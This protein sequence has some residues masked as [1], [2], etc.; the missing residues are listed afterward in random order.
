MHVLP[1][2]QRVGVSTCFAWVSSAFTRVPH[3][4]GMLRTRQPCGE[5]IVVRAV[6]SIFLW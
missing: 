2:T 1:T 3:G 4:A 6:L 5:F